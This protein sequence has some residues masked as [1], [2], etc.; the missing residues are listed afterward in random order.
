MFFRISITAVIFIA[1]IWGDIIAQ[2]SIKFAPLNPAF[3]KYQK[4]SL[5]KP[6][7]SDYVPAPVLPR[8]SIPESYRYD[9]DLPSDYDMRNGDWLTPIRDQMQ[10]PLCWAYAAF[11]AIESQIK[12]LG[13]G[14]TNLSEKCLQEFHSNYYY[15]EG[16]N[17]QM[18][19]SYL[20]TYNGPVLEENSS[21]YQ[22][23][24]AGT[25][26]YSNYVNE[27]T[28]SHGNIKP[29]SFLS[30]ILN[31]ED[32]LHN[33]IKHTI[34]KTGAV[35]TTMYF[36]NE[37]Y[38]AK[39]YTYYCDSTSKEVNHAVVLIGWNDTMKTAAL[40]PGAWIVRNSWGTSF[41]E[42]GY[43]YLSYSDSVA[44]HGENYIWPIIED[45]N[46]DAYLYMNDQLGGISCL[47][48]KNET[49]AYGL[50]KFEAQI[51]L[52]ITK[53]MTW[54]KEGNS[55]VSVW[56]YDNFDG[57]NLNGLLGESLNNYR[58]YAGYF[59]V[60]LPVPIYLSAGNDFY[61]KIKYEYPDTLLPPVP[62]ELE[63]E[64]YCSP[65][66]R[67]GKYWISLDD[68]DWY[69][70]GAGTDFLVNLSIRAYAQ[71]VK[72]DWVFQESAVKNNLN[73]IF[74]TNESKGYVVGDS[75]IILKTA[76]G[77]SNWSAKSSGSSYNLSSIFFADESNGWTVGANGKIYN[78]LDGGE[79]WSPQTSNTGN[80]LGSV[81]FYDK[82][83]GYAV[84]EL[85]KILKTTNG[86][87][88][89]TTVQRVNGDNLNFISFKNS[90]VG[91]AAGQN[92]IIIKTTNGGANWTKK[93]SSTSS[94]ISSFCFVD[95]NT[96][97]A[98]AGN[99]TI[100]KTIDGGENWIKQISP[101]SF[102]LYSIWFCD[103]DTGWIV[104]D[105]GTILKTTDAGLSW[106]YQ[107]SGTNNFLYSLFFPTPAKGF[108]AGGAGTIL[109]K[110]GGLVH[111]EEVINLPANFILHQ[112]YPN[113][114]NPTTVIS[115]QLSAL[116]YVTLR[117]YDILGR[118]VAA[119]V[120]EEKPAGK[121]Q[122][123]FNASHLASGIYYYRISAG[124]FIAAKKMILLK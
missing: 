85:G 50:A 100:L 71:P 88:N 16:G 1:A 23:L 42:G 109:K 110:T 92:G 12:G 99:G 38:N 39:N 107:P 67:T 10:T 122:V 68:N 103:K 81:F 9:D 52:P 65:L 54:T 79:T 20:S 124:N 43:F 56:I 63:I 59:M 76:N 62:C 77:G 72:T 55:K 113:P 18:T 19:D 31:R 40:E 87:T 64:K 94:L 27:A 32:T 78:T 84:G 95:S 96:G 80:W 90:S 106:K 111:V 116:S 15:T 2:S 74:F 73:G 61:I 121:Y 112:N 24:K 91:W 8:S 60:D 49:Y 58:E 21:C 117:I 105:K 11:G 25:V 37:Y 4:T 33:M 123:E 89:W 118:E 5:A 51:N 102:N 45:Y 115:Y 114:F 17:F 93:N 34:Y 86:G 6:K 104:G 97:W 48:Y 57:S 41:G 7:A 119:L 3:I 75:G 44:L 101:T 46:A 13:R 29:S 14:S 98:A 53:I 82:N 83:N 36:G 108:I 47:G 26:T 120:N 22:A 70:L 66:I 30:G 35:S 28:G 69:L